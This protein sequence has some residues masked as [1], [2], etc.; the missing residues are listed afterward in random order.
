MTAYLIA[1]AAASVFWA[2]MIAFSLAHPMAGL[3]EPHLSPSRKD[4]VCGAVVSW[5]IFTAITWLIVAFW[6]FVCQVIGGLL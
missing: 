3:D 5:A 4:V 6:I 1:L 2:V